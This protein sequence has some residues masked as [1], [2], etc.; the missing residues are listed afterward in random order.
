MALWSSLGVSYHLISPRAYFSSVSPIVSWIHF[1]ASGEKSNSCR[2]ST[3]YPGG[4]IRIS[5]LLWVSLS[6]W[7]KSPDISRSA[8]RAKASAHSFSSVGIRRVT[9]TLSTRDFFVWEGGWGRGGIIAKNYDD[10]IV[11][12]FSLEAIL[13]RI[14]WRA[15]SQKLITITDPEKIIVVQE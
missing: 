8:S 13:L 12:A 5:H 1:H 10:Y 11:I 7:I 9:E 14:I 2:C 4:A 15:I 3:W 6:D